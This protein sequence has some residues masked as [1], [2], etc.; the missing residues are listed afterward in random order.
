[1]PSVAQRRRRAQRQGLWRTGH[2][3]W[4]QP[5]LFV[6]SKSAISEE[7]RRRRD[8][9]ASSWFA[10]GVGHHPASPFRSPLRRRARVRLNSETG[11]PPP[12]VSSSETS[13][14]LGR[15][16]RNC[17]HFVANRVEITRESTVKS[18]CKRFLL[19]AERPSS[20]PRLPLAA[21]KTLPISSTNQSLN[22]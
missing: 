22:R 14:Q 9:P 4:C 1:M 21:R 12:E 10:L 13:S 7:I 15:L 11:F 20:N 5:G 18:C 16:H 8:Y 6:T 3:P 17:V 2:R 19:H